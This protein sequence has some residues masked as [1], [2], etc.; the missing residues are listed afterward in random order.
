MKFNVCMKHIFVWGALSLC[1]VQGWSQATVSDFIRS[2]VLAP[3]VQVFDDQLSFLNEKSYR[4]SPLQ[5]FEFRFRNREMKE[6]YNEFGLRFSPTNPWEMKYTNKYFLAMQGSIS[7]E[8]EVLLKEVLVE[9]Y[10]QVAY[11]LY[12]NELRTLYEDVRELVDRQIAILEKQ[13]T[14]SFFDADDYVEL[15]MKQ[16]NRMVEFEE[17]DFEFKDQLRKIEKTYTKNGSVSMHWDESKF[18]TVAKIKA[19]VDSLSREELKPAEV[20]FQ[21]YR[22]EMAEHDYKLEKSNFNLGFFQT[23][24]DNRRAIQD[25]VPVNISFGI[26]IP[27]TNPNKGDMAKRRVK[28]IQEE[29]ELKDVTDVA[30]VDRQVAYQNL[31]SLIQR[32]EILEERIVELENSKLIKSLSTLKGGDPLIVVQYREDILKLSTLLVKLKR[33]INLMYID[34]LAASD[35]IQRSPLVNFLYQDLERL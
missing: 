2:S 21:E 15:K 26:N 11:T 18:I 30:S 23:S 10:Y 24:Y 28:A 32:Y 16:L 6:G 22:V 25:R 12:Y 35:H 29:F 9:R 3:Q 7:S 1:T 4:L 14:S 5:K 33:D 8:R 27:I 34:Y 19:L 17:A 31:L 20:A 13:Q